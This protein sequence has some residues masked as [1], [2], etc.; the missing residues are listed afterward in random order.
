TCRLLT[1]QRSPAQEAKNLNGL[2]EWLAT[3]QAGPATPAV[4]KGMREAL[5]GRLFERPPEA[6]RPRG[7]ILRRFVSADIQENYL[8]LGVIFNDQ[9]IIGS[10][11]QLEL[12]G[13]VLGKE[14]PF[15]VEARRSALRCLLLRP[16][17]KL[18]ELLR[19]LLNDVALRS[20]AIRALAAFGLPE[21]P[22]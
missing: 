9:Q 20:D 15:N 19:E 1:L 16:N 21:T 17:E 12:V 13:L 18:Y 11:F 6:W 8:V 5:A 3:E 22:K 4:L 10:L 7:E 14:R 2:I